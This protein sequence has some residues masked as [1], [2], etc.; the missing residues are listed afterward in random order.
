LTL[1]ATRAAARGLKR[2]RRVSDRVSVRFTAS[3]G[4]GR[5]ARSNVVRLRR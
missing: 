3:D 4:A 2:G 1:K 5:T